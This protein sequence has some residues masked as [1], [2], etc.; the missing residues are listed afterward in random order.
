MPSK[1]PRVRTAILAGLAALSLGGV[2][3]AATGMSPA[4]AER[5]TQAASGSS[6]GKA[7]ASA[8]GAAARPTPLLAT[9]A[10][11]RPGRTRPGPPGTGCARPGP[12]GRATTTASDRTRRRSRPSRTPPAAPTRSRPTVRPRPPARTPTDSD[13]PRPPAAT[14][15]ASR[16]PPPPARRPTRATATARARAARRRPPDR[17][18]SGEEGDEGPT[19]DGLTSR[20]AMGMTYRGAGHHHIDDGH[21]TSPAKTSAR[22]R[23]GLRTSGAGSAVWRCCRF[24]P[25]GRL[26]PAPFVH[27]APPG[28]AGTRSSAAPGGVRPDRRLQRRLRPR[29]NDDVDFVSGWAAVAP[30][31]ADWTAGDSARLQ[32]HLLRVRSADARPAEPHH[33]PRA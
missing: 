30:P 16:R 23:G 2:A 26:A 3:A 11:T 10:T 28:P 4:S 31:P 14:S 8:H 33:R 19:G 15:T 9:R 5:A 13:R 6:A 27:P 12:P 17:P 21:P 18:C 20:D 25:G 1:L 29:H 24:C 22:G 32:R 7:A